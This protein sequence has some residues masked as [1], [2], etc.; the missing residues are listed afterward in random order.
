MRASRRRWRG[1]G[2]SEGHRRACGSKGAFEHLPEPPWG[3][4]S[5]FTERTCT[6]THTREGGCEPV[7]PN[8]LPVEDTAVHWNVRDS[9]G[10]F[11]G[12]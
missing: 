5:G 6:L 8:K 11:S 4:M 2:N 7:G 10:G 12:G 1:A 3:R 9:A